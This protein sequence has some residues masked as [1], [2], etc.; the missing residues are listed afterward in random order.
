MS[1]QITYYEAL[2][3]FVARR[4]IDTSHN[5]YV[6]HDEKTVT[7]REQ[8]FDEHYETREREQT[9]SR[10]FELVKTKLIKHLQSHVSR[11][12]ENI[13]RIEEQTETNIYGFKS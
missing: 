10:N 4:V 3:C 13:Q 5:D 11:I 7:V 1:E 12:Q 9:F 2:D 8:Y 6:T